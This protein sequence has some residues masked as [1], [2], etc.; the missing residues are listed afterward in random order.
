[1]NTPTPPSENVTVL[2]R[3]GRT[4]YLVGT[5]HISQRSV[6]EVKQVIDT[7]RPDTVCVELCQTR[8]D[9]L[10]DPDRWKKLDIFQIIRQGKVLFLLANLTLSAYQ[11]KMGEKLGATPGAEMTAAIE[12][13]REQGAELVLADRDIQATLK[14]TWS[15]M[16]FLDKMRVLG[17][18]M[19]V[20]FGGGEGLTEE[21]LEKMKDK[22]TLGEMMAEFARQ[23]PGVKTPLIDERDQFLM[24]ATEDAPGETVVSVV[25]A[26]HVPGMVKRFGESADRAALS[27]IP[28]TPMWVRSLKWIIPSLILLAFYFGYQKHQG[29]GLEQM[30]YAWVLP[31]SIVCAVLTAIAGGK[32]LSILTAFVASPI[33][34][35]NPTLG[36]GMVVGL[37]E[38][39]LRKPTVADCEEV[40]NDVTSVKG[41]YR[42][43]FL[44][45]LLV[46]AAATLGS[47][48]GAWIGA[49]WVVN[50]L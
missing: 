9:T 49:F 21:D 18:Q 3:D 45:V 47:A 37:L 19:G 34:S 14:R 50:L 44:R 36:A 8:Y 17:E 35:L 13:A 43:P 41:F 48:L 31:N 6:E 39:W 7:V 11:R 20:F 28:P 32:L 29:E 12:K 10:N 1:M 25:G 26:A 23:V 40:P 38:A 46:A 15:N 5:A 33:T 2:Q 16:S 4:F 27:I 24:S 42:N 22:D 30:L